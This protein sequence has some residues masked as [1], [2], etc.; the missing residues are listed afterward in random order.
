VNTQ[1]IKNIVKG[2][3]TDE[4]TADWYMKR[5]EICSACKYN[6]SNKEDISAVEKLK[7]NSICGGPVCTACGCCVSKKARVEESVCGLEEIGETPLWGSVVASNPIDKSLKVFTP[8]G[9]TSIEMGKDLVNIYREYGEE[10]L[11]L[12]FNLVF[13]RKGGIE[14]VS[15]DGSC[16]CTASE[17]EK[18]DSENFRLLVQISTKK[19]KGTSSSRGMKVDYQVSKDKKMSVRLN[20]IMNKN[21]R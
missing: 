11:R 2:F 13:Q 18:I 16:S 21:G 3:T 6:S 10:D 12:N 9:G 1:K 15:A 14:L 4:P 17:N 7:V 5:M 19:F 8:D 20:F